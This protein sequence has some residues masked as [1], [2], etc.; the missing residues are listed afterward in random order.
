MIRLGIIGAGIMGAK[1]AQTVSALPGVRLTAVADP[2]HERAGEL[3]SR[4]GGTAFADYPELLA[5]GLV[6]A[7]YVGLPHDGHLA[8]CVTAAGHGVHVLID[9]PLCNDVAEADQI[10]AARDKA[11]IVLMVGFS[12]RFRAEWREAHRL[13]ASG[14]IGEPVS[15]TDV[16]AEAMTHTPAWYWDVGRGGGI[17]QLQAHHCLDRLPWLVGA[18]L[19]EVTCRTAGLPGEAASAATLT[20]G[21]AG[22]AVAGIALSFGR[23]YQA[24]VQA[25]MLVQGTAGELRIDQDRVLS[26]RS[27]TMERT[28]SYADDDWLARQMS[29]FVRSCAGTRD[30]APTAEDGRRAMVYAAAAAESARTGRTVTLR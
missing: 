2:A 19:A 14:V 18:P 22:G 1:V 27:A 11:D 25:L 8:A 17:L 15:V 30:A 21:F 7:V 12:Y 6:D 28:E 4:Y 24:D 20:A 26:V 13:I 3:T 5:S 10:I 9:K 16:I 23:T 29:A